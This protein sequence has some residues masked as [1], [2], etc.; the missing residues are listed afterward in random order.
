MKIVSEKRFEDVYMFNLGFSYVGK[1]LM[2]VYFYLLDK[3]LIDTGQS[4]MGDEVINLLNG[5]DIDFVL[6]T[7]HH[8]DHSGNAY[9]IR[10]RFSVDIYCNKQ[11]AEKLKKGF[12]IMFYQKYVWGSGK[13]VECCTIKGDITYGRF[14]IV[15]IHT[16]GHSKDHTAFYIPDKGYLFSGDLYLADRIKYFRSDQ[17]ICDEIKSIKKVLEYDFDT[18]FCGHRPRLKNGKKHLVT[19]LDFLENIYGE[20]AHLIN[21]GYGEAE[22]MKKIKLKEVWPVKLFTQGNVSAKNIVRS[23]I[24]CEKEKGLK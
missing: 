7:H 14:K 22:I 10:E 18:L 5:K 17:W 15:P 3:I 4:H 8:E 11:G 6:L 21:Y 16:P 9:L 20:V 13:P 2:S 1:P 19:K 24:R 12:N 23:V